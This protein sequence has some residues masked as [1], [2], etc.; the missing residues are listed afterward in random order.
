VSVLVASVLVH[1]SHI[2]NQQ[3]IRLTLFR[4][5]SYTHS[6]ALWMQHDISFIIV[7]QHSAG[8]VNKIRLISTS[9][10]TCSLLLLRTGHYAPRLWSHMVSRAE[11]RYDAAHVVRVGGTTLLISFIAFSSQIWIVYPWYGRELSLDLIKLLIPF[12]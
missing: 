7:A 4:R 9:I 5:A 12:K 10:S 11:V 8:C 2:L 1:K 6:L 3:P